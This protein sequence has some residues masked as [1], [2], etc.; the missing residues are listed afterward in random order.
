M[1]DQQRLYRLVNLPRVEN[2][3]LELM[4]PPGVSG[5]ALTFG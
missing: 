3:V 2:R 4:F 1:I 5:F